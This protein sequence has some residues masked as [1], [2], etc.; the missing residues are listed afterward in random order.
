MNLEIRDLAIRMSETD[1]HE[2]AAS[3]KPAAAPAN[4]FTL[5]VPPFGV[6][7]LSVTGLAYRDQRERTRAIEESHATTSSAG[8][9]ASAELAGLEEMSALGDGGLWG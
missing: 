5:E 2:D 6:L 9:S 3:G 4:R 7:P 1:R 8:M